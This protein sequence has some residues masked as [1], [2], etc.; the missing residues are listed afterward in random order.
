MTLSGRIQDP[1]F[2]EAVALIGRRWRVPI[3]EELAH[4]PRTFEQLR[5]AVPD[6]PQ[7]LLSRHVSGLESARLVHL[8]ADPE[9]PSD[10]AYA[11]TDSG[12]ELCDLIEDVEH[13]A[14]RWL[15]PPA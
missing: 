5:V 3:L 1:Y 11:L 4:G 2:D 10:V 8:V 9:M 15:R 13:W 6:L 7:S 12:R 14:H